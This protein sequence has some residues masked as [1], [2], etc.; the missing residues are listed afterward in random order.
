MK[1]LCAQLDSQSKPNPL[2]SIF[3]IKSLAK[4][5]GRTR[6]FRQF[7]ITLIQIDPESNT[8]NAL[9]T[10]DDSEAILDERPEKS[11]KR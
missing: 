3:Q 11:R 7:Y 8:G 2:Y 4:N 6:L 5:Y 10:D 9:I 1:A